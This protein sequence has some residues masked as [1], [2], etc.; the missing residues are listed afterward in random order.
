MRNNNDTTEPLTAAEGCLMKDIAGTD[1]GKRCMDFDS[2][3]DDDSG[4]GMDENRRGEEVIAGDDTTDVDEFDDKVSS[5]QSIHG[6]KTILIPR[7]C[8]WANFVSRSQRDHHGAVVQPITGETFERKVQFP[9]DESKLH[10]V[11]EIDEIPDEIK[12][13]Y[14]LNES[15]ISRFENDVKLTLFRWSNHRSGKIHFDGINNS[16]RGLEGI[17]EGTERADSLKIWR[18][19]KNVLG[20]INRQRHKGKS[21]GEIDWEKV[22]E[23]SLKSSSWHSER[24]S[25]MGLA[26]E[27]ERDRAWNE[28]VANLK[29]VVNLGKKKKSKGKGLFF[30]RK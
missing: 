11:H 1:E 18:H 14:W 30:W 10:L 16:I 5:V 19:S 25:K 20:E 29:E 2:C 28:Q 27:V 13:D 7:N 24:A 3:R 8:S 21:F 22:R 17:I 23:A 26:D 15:D 9:R 6:G 4:R 12:P